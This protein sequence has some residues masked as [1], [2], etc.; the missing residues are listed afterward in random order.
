MPRSAPLLAGLLLLGCGGKPLD[1]PAP[2]PEQIAEADPDLVQA[3]ARALEDARAA[4]RSPAVFFE[5]AMVYQANDLLELAVVAY[6]QGLAQGE[7]ARPWYHLARARLDLGDPVGALHALERSVAL[8]PDYA[9]SHTRRGEILYEFGRAD[10]AAASFRRALELEPEE[11]PAMLGLARADLQRGD[12]REAAQRIETLLE[13]HPHERFANGLLARARRELGLNE[14]AHGAERRET[15]ARAATRV[16]PWAAEVEM[17]AQGVFVQLDR[18]GRALQSGNTPAA[19]E[20]LEPL[21]ARRPD[22]F[23]V[24][25]LLA[26]ALILAGD[27][28]RARTLLAEAQ[29]AET[30]AFRREL[31]L[32]RACLG[33]S[34]AARAREHLERAVELHPASEEAHVALGEAALAL[35]AFDDAERSLRRALELG[36][37]SVREWVLLARAALGAGRPAQASATLGEALAQYPQSATLLAYLAESLLAE[38]RPQE[39]REALARATERD[40]ANELLPRLRARL[41]EE[42]AE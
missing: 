6:E 22:S 13:R 39:A 18:A 26:Q 42:G 37:Q 12:A 28:A 23:Q 15:R 33:L 9:P 21:H 10:E 11:V 40:P 36:E 24:L 41:A 3:I 1:P 16:D 2:S 34:D 32:G 29:V 5:L 38:G 30:D 35:G 4:P 17:R 14:L 27:P 8:Q 19:L 31:G 20:I 7:D 25:D